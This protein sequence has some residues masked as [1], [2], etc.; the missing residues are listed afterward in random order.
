M[1]RKKGCRRMRCRACGSLQTVKNGRRVIIQVSVDRKVTRRVHRY[2]CR[3]CGRYF[4]VRREARQRYSWGF[5]LR[6]VQMHVEERMSYRVISKRLH[7]VVGKRISPRRLCQ[8]VNAVA[9]EANSS[10]ELQQLFHPQWE[11]YLQV[12]DKNLNVRGAL[13]KSLVAVDRTG[14]AVHYALLSEPTQQQHTEFFET[15]VTELQYGVR[16]ITTDFDPLLVE[17]VRQVLP[18]N[19]L[20]QGCLWHAKELLKVMIDYAATE[21][22]Y[23]HLQGKVH[24][25]REELIDHKPHYNT[26]PLERA[27][28][29]LKDLEVLYHHKKAFLDDIMAMLYQEQRRRSAAQWRT[30]KKR[31]GRAYPKAIGW[32]GTM[33]TMLLAHQRDPHLAKTNAQAENFNRQLKRRFKTIEAFQSA[34]TAHNYLKLLCGYLRCKP[35]TDCRGRR[36][37]YNGKAPL[38]VC[39]VQ[40]HHH[41]WIKYVVPCS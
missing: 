10:S 27:E 30:L 41:Q 7:E 4:I 23:K 19:V 12:D 16:G 38:E 13:R 34:S 9:V 31:Y 11:G 26:Q 17:A 25:W 28:A 18:R 32:I 37:L 35:Y 20:H 8:M 14:D 21:R 39:H 5:M 1:E 29:T 22:K 33:W 3:R 24:R 15:I 2:R 40:L 6:V 36:K